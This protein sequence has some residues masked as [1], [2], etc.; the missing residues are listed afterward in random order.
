M[1]NELL[2]FE[3]IGR[4]ANITSS[5][6]IGERVG[7]VCNQ[8]SSFSLQSFKRPIISIDLNVGRRRIQ[9]PNGCY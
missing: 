8:C 2:T 3:L 1:A 9:C 5:R 4:N 6:K 7:V